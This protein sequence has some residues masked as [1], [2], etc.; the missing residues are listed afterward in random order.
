METVV[1]NETGFLIDV[2]NATQLAQKISQILAMP[3]M[4]IANLT[5]L[6][7][8]RVKSL[9]SAAQL[10]EKTLGVYKEIMK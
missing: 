4:E 7:Q 6:A 1:D 10:Q 9:F 8:K 3:P 5:K 2:G